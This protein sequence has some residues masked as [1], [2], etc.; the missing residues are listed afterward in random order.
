MSAV[1]QKY[2]LKE[3]GP[4]VETDWCKTANRKELQKGS[5]KVWRSYIFVCICQIGPITAGASSS[6]DKEGPKSNSAKRRMCGT[7]RR[8]LCWKDS[9]TGEIGGPTGNLSSHL[10]ETHWNSD[11]VPIMEK[12]PHSKLRVDPQTNTH[13]RFYDFLTAFPIH[14]KLVEWIVKDWRPFTITRSVAFRAFGW[15][16][17]KRYV[18]CKHYIYD[19]DHGS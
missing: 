2:R 16:L 4:A 3:D 10:E 17:D 13:Y 19:Q 11:Y 14:I 7:Q 9:K 18:P 8:Q 6:G 15:A 1:R 12:N 5:T